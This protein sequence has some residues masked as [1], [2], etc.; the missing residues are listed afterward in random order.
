VDERPLI[1]IGINETRDI[2]TQVV[3]ASDTNSKVSSRTYDNLGNNK[4][5]YIRLLGAIPPGGK[6]FFVVG[7]QYNHN[8][9]EGSYENQPL[10]FRKGTWTIFT[11]HQ[12]KLTP[13]TQLMLHGFARFNGQQQFYELSNFGELRFSINQQFLKKKL[14]LTLSMSDLFGTNRNE[15][16]IDQGSVHATGVRSSDTRRFGFNL[17]YNFGIRKKEEAGNLFNVEPPAN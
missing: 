10:S 11:F 17:R 16:S 9:Y 7:G 6:Y 4:E 8:H 3:Y 12:L 15:F 1:A 2:F 5:T 14:N 13:L